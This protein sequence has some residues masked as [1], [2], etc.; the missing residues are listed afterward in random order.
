MGRELTWLVWLGRMEVVST[1]ACV[2]VVACGLDIN[3]LGKQSQGMEPV[4][5]SVGKEDELLELD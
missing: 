2:R 3:M 1:P 4:S 5:E